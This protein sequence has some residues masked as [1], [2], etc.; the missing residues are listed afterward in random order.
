MKFSEYQA[1]IEHTR[2][3]YVDKI[4]EICGDEDNDMFKLLSLIYPALGL[5]E[6]GELQGKVKKVIRDS[7]GKVTDEAR[8]TLA[9]ELGDS[10]WYHA[11]L[12]TELGLDL[13]EVAAAN[14]AKLADRKERGV[15]GGSGDNR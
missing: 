4:K 12:A 2:Y 5:S 15:L 6:V 8:A 14:L 1:G 10:L 11:A 13:G 9:K 3:F 7:G